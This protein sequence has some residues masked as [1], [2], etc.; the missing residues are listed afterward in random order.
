MQ[1]A[2]VNEA[3]LGPAVGALPSA[4]LLQHASHVAAARRACECFL[5]QRAALCQLAVHRCAPGDAIAQ[6]RG[7]AH[8][9]T[10]QVRW[11]DESAPRANKDLIVFSERPADHRIPAHRRVVPAD[12]LRL[13]VVDARRVGGGGGERRAADGA[14]VVC[15]GALRKR[16]VASQAT[17]V[18]PT[19]CH[20]PGS[21]CCVSSHAHAAHMHVTLSRTQHNLKGAICQLR[22][23]VLS[24]LDVTLPADDMHAGAWI[25]LAH[26]TSSGSTRTGVCTKLRADTQLSAARPS[27]SAPIPCMMLC[28]RTG[29]L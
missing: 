15:V 19:S 20:A 12:L 22:S 26:S 21:R 7:C 28:S 27:A 8:V 23:N 1:H 17:G 13:H 25:T 9:H 16:R 18:S 2:H 24:S 5:F 14:P 6:C 10:L 11:A 3:A 4:Q 29:A